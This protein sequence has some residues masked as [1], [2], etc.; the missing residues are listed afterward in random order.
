MKIEIKK[1]EYGLPDAYTSVADVIR[2]WCEKN[3]R[4]EDFIVRIRTTVLGEET[5]LLLFNSF[6]EGE[7]LFEWED[8][9]YEGGEVEL[10]GFMP[11]EEVEI[12]EKY[13]C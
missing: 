2:Q 9:W 12:P 11:L 13:R 5:T 4:Y 6:E 7:D 10:L 8:D 3:N 1:D